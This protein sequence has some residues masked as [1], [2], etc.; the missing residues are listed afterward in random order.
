[1]RALIVQNVSREKSGLIEEVLTQRNIEFEIIDLNEGD[2]PEPANYD[3]AFILGGPDSANDKTPKMKMELQSVKEIIGLEIPYFGICLGMQILV[4]ANGG[5]VFPNQVKE[6]GCKDGNDKYYGVE[7]T[8][9]GVKD[10]IF[11]GISSP[12]KIFQLHGETVFLKNGMKLLGIGEHCKNQ[13]IKVGN[14]AYGVQGHLEITEPMLK[15]WLAEDAM[16]DS[17]DKNTILKDFRDNKEEY[18]NNGLRLINNFL[19]IVEKQKKIAK[20]A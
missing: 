19:D 13:I 2:F 10:S 9:E 1:M 11:A 8:Q 3:M 15:D 6:V 14:N 7:L 4:K 12:F 16:F 17:F 20:F 18:R 5:N